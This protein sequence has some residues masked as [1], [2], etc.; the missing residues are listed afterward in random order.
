MEPNVSKMVSLTGHNYHIWKGKMKDLLL[1]KNL[2]LPVFGTKP[3]NISDDDWNFRHEQVCGYI[4]GWVEDNVRN[5]ISNETNAKT[6]WE[7][8]QKLY[9]ST[10][11]NN[12][13]YLLN[14]AMNLRYKKGTPILDHVNNFEGCFD[15]LS[16]MG[17][18][19]DDE[20]LGL[21]LLNT[22]PDAW[23]NYRVSLANS[24]P[25]GSVSFE[26]AKASILNEEVRRK[27]QGLISSKSDI[28]AGMT[29]EHM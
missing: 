22:L 23:E 27:N 29:S 20:I 17:I 11:G 12:K 2:H 5:L 7:K 9:A 24:A 18:K 6:L 26:Y 28:L 25:E 16:G 3:E 10:T 13:L 15:Q 19:F 1:V 14:Q 21:W 8:L 4:R